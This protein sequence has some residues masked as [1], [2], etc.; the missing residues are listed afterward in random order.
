[1]KIN[2]AS[3]DKFL[4]LYIIPFE[5]VVIDFG[6]VMRENYAVSKF[7]LIILHLFFYISIVTS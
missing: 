6:G 2:F 4:S 5:V 1:M 3:R 7:S